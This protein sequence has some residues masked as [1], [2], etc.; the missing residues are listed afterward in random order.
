MKHLRLQTAPFRGTKGISKGGKSCRAAWTCRHLR[1]AQHSESEAPMPGATLPVLVSVIRRVAMRA[2]SLSTGLRRF[3][4]DEDT[5][6]D[7]RE[8]W[9]ASFSLSTFAAPV[10]NWGQRNL[11]SLQHFLWVLR[12]WPGPGYTLTFISRYGN[13]HDKEGFFTVSRCHIPSH[14]RTVFALVSFDKVLGLELAMKENVFM[15]L[16]TGGQ[17]KSLKVHDK[18]HFKT[19]AARQLTVCDS[20]WQCSLLSL[21]LSCQCCKN[22]MSWSAG[23][24]LVVELVP[25]TAEAV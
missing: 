9:T 10:L 24:V 3:K 15:V 12:E 14:S 16:G 2:T 7:V 22:V 13:R 23:M 6:N 11:Q 8:D 18:T 20:M 4:K 21:W 17:S 25:G 1:S 19:V 5:F